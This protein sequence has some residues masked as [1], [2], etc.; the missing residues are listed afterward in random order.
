MVD[1]D[2]RSWLAGSRGMA[3]EE[4]KVYVTGFWRLDK[5]EFYA[6]PLQEERRMVERS[7]DDGWAIAIPKEFNHYDRGHHE[8]SRL[9]PVWIE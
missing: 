9:P 4:E 6:G 7:Q 3:D 5:S 2:V 8:T 1:M